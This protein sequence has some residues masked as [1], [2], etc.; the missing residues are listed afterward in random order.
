MSVEESRAYREAHPDRPFLLLTIA[1]FSI[2]SVLF[3]TWAG[4]GIIKRDLPICATLAGIAIAFVFFIAAMTENIGYSIEYMAT[5][6]GGGAYTESLNPLLYLGGG[7]VTDSAVGSILYPLLSAMSIGNLILYLA[8]G[9]LISFS[10]MGFYLLSKKQY[11]KAHTIELITILIGAAIA[12]LTLCSDYTA[13]YS[14]PSYVVHGVFLKLVE[15]MGMSLLPPQRYY[16][17]P[18]EGLV[19]APLSLADLF[20]LYFP[21]AY[22]AFLIIEVLRYHRWNKKQTVQ[23]TVF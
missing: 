18:I 21:V 22:L 7:T 14:Q 6:W 17:V 1:L 5:I 13:L 2:G 8:Y 12:V 4:I 3:L 20:S 11:F 16:Y 15:P 10:L 9:E 23:N 19:L